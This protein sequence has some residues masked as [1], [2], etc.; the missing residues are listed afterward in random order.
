MDNLLDRLRAG[1]LDTN[2]KRRGDRSAGRERR[3]HRS[4]SVAV[5]AEDLLKSIQTD[6][7]SPPLPRSR[8]TD[9]KKFGL[10]DDL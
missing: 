1:D 7:D 8:A 5:M 9:R 6:E 10:Q 3:L 2:S 4:E